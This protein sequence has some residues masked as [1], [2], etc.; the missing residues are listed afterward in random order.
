MTNKELFQSIYSDTIDPE[1]KIDRN[2]VKR[3]QLVSDCFDAQRHF[4]DVPGVTEEIRTAFEA[5]LEKMK[6]LSEF[7]RVDMYGIGFRQG[8]RLAFAMME[9]P[10]DPNPDEPDDP[11]E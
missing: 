7:E 3:L 8:G 1:N 9:T 6:T 4:L 10:I 11:T 5:V 2:S